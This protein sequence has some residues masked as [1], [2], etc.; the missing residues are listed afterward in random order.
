MLSGIVY[1][2]PSMLVS[3]LSVSSQCYCVTEVS[4]DHYTPHLLTSAACLPPRGLVSAIL[5]PSHT[6]LDVFP[7]LPLDYELKSFIFEPLGP[8]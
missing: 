2:Q 1:T 6:V 4:P 7:D 3:I 5:G 8:I